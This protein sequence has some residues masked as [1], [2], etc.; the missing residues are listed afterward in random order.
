MHD[1]PHD[2]RL[3]IDTGNDGR[4]SES[5]ETEVDMLRQRGNRLEQH[6]E[7]RTT[8]QTLYDAVRAC[9]EVSDLLR[10]VSAAIVGRA[11][12]SDADFLL[13]AIDGGL[14]QVDGALAHGYESH[15]QELAPIKYRL[16]VATAIARYCA[17][18]LQNSMASS[19]SA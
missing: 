13:R 8:Y 14:A 5:W 7:S 9:H 2:P 1:A 6:L 12:Q 10:D 4:G 3:L 11:E 17:D 19:N 15:G 18:S 16:R